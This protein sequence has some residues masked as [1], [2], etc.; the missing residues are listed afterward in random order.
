[1]RWEWHRQTKSYTI[2]IDNPLPVPELKF[3]Q[4][5]ING[6]ALD[7]VPADQSTITW[8]VPFT[9]DGGAFIAPNMPLLFDGASS[10][11]SDPMFENMKST[12]QDDP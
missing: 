6:T 11:D 2:R 10:Y 1:M 12:N 7:Y 5:S 8:Q 4:P 3:R 9:E